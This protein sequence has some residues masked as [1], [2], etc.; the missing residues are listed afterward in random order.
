MQDPDVYLLD[1]PLSAV[2]P[3]VSRHLFDVCIN[4]ALV[5]KTRVLVTHQLQCVSSLRRRVHS[6]EIRVSSVVMKE[7][8]DSDEH[9]STMDSR[10]YRRIAGASHALQ[11]SHIHAP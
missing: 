4:T 3:H 2:D 8:S 5:G 10:E 1:D 7:V 6:F 9:T 11:C